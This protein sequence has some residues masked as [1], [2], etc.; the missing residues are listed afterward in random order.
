MQQYRMNQ[1]IPESL[2]SSL[3]GTYRAFGWIPSDPHSAMLSHAY[4]T[5]GMVLGHALFSPTTEQLPL[6]QS[7]AKGQI[8]S[9]LNH[10]SI[11]REVKT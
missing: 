3:L 6:L 2:G 8:I 10:D 4:G 7:Q 1:H 9:D 5:E 11:I